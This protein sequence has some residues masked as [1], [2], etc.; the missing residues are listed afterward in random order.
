MVIE[1]SA[2]LNGLSRALLLFLI[3]SGLSLIFGLMGVVNFAHGAFYALG[4]YLAVSVFGVADSFLVALLVAPVLVALI[5]MVAEVTTIRPLYDRD[6]IYQVLLTFGVAIIIDELVK[7]IWGSSP[8]NLSTPEMVGGVS[9]LGFTTYPTYRLFIIVF[10]LLMALALWLFIQR[11][12]VGIIVR[13]GTL[14]SEMV[15]AMGINVRQVFT[16][17][18]GLGVALAAV[19]G[20]IASPLLGVYPSMGIEILIEAFLVVVLGGLG[21][22]RGALLGS[23][24]IGM[25]QGIGAYYISEFVGLLLFIIMIAVLLVRPYGLMGTP[26]I[27]EH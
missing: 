20:V 14:D 11:T 21:N 25:A 16:G 9:D 8:L 23:L 15:E 17:M 13:A 27:A 26:G 5:G 1:T 19:G 10:G 12:R 7:V 22:V 3:A 18:F 6:P 2:I 4:A 24:I